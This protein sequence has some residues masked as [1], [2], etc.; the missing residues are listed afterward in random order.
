MLELKKKPIHCIYCGSTQLF[1]KGKLYSGTQEMYACLSCKK[2]ML[3]LV[4]DK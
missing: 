2:N 1:Y 4:D 3:S